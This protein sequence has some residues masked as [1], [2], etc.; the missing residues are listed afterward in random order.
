MLGQL[1]SHKMVG[2]EEYH[3]YVCSMHSS[4]EEEFHMYVCSMHSSNEEEY[5]MYVCM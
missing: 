3:M 1:R 2:Q 5:Y 4:N